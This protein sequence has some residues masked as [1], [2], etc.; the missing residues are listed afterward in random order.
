MTKF[1]KIILKLAFY[2]KTILKHGKSAKHLKT[3]LKKNDLLATVAH[4]ALSDKFS[5]SL[6]AGKVSDV[7][8]FCWLSEIENQRQPDGKYQMFIPS[9]A[10]TWYRIGSHVLPLLYRLRRLCSPLLFRFCKRPLSK[11][12]LYMQYHFSC[13]RCGPCTRGNSVCWQ[14]LLKRGKAPNFGH[15]HHQRLRVDIINKYCFKKTS[16]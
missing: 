12:Y 3:R 13:S 1:Y 5:C 7:K 10:V 9:D 8:N 6:S 4:R 16:S 2:D 15:G 14:R 11:E